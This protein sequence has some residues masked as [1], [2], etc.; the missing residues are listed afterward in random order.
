VLL[1]VRIS[2]AN[3]C[4][5]G[6]DIDA[7]VNGVVADVNDVVVVDVVVD[8]DVDI[9]VDVADV[10]AILSIFCLANLLALTTED[11]DADV[12]NSGLLD[13]RLQSLTCCSLLSIEEVLDKRSCRRLNGLGLPSLFAST[14][15]FP[16]PCCLL[17]RSPPPPPS[18][19]SVTAN[20]T[21]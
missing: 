4:F 6:E 12:V 8:V 13:V 17:C 10:S 7:D 14:P 3:C 1:V 19:S 21:E 20:G 18:C 15:L 11:I 16:I 9:D 5:F 2:S